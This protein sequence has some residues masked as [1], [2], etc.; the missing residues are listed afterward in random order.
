MGM[1]AAM[2]Q[3]TVGLLGGTAEVFELRSGLTRGDGLTPMIFKL[4]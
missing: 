4:T 1:S 3:L 2:V